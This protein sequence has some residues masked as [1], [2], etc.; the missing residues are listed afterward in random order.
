[1]R[2]QVQGNMESTALAAPRMPWYQPQWAIRL[3]LW[4]QALSRVAAFAATTAAP[5]VGVHG[6]QVRT[7]PIGNSVKCWC[8]TTHIPLHL[9]FQ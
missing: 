9:Y 6:L 5:C 4:L 3:Q 2:N 7:T 8:C 1:M